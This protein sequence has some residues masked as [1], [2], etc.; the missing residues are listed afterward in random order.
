VDIESLS[1]ILGLKASKKELDSTVIIVENI[2]S[3]L[4]NLSLLQVEFAK[5]LL[6]SKSSSSMKAQE[7]INMKI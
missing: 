3:R 5:V 7:S 4:R 6:P 2:F 1:K